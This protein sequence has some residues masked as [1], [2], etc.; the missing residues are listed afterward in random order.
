MLSKTFCILYYLIIN[1]MC[2]T[3]A[4]VVLFHQIQLHE[5]LWLKTLHYYLLI[6]YYL[7]VLKILINIQMAELA[8][9]D[10]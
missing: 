9:W 6:L 1:H 5:I 7:I 2:L 8:L 10:S 3:R 4:L